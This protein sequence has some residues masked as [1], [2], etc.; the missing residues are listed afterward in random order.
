MKKENKTS[1][2]K[3]ITSYMYGGMVTNKNN[4]KKKYGSG[5]MVKKP[6]SCK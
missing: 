4:K 1:G 5:G 6:G 3:V 2:S